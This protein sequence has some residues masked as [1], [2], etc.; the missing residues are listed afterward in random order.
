MVTVGPRRVAAVNVSIPP[1]ALRVGD[2]V[3][4]A[5]VP[6]DKHHGPIAQPVRWLSEDPAVA[7]VADDGTLTA[8]AAG[9]VLVWAEA[10]GVRGT[11][12]VEVTPA[13]VVSI[14]LGPIPESIGAGETFTVAATPVD[15]QGNTL[16]GRVCVWSSGNEAVGTVTEDG[17]VHT[18][19]SGSLPLVC[20]CEGKVVT[21]SVV[22]GWGAVQSVFISPPPP[23]IEAGVPFTLEAWVVSETGAVVDSSEVSWASSDPDLAMVAAGGRVSPRAPGDVVITASAGGVDASVS[24]GVAPSS[25]GWQPPESDEAIVEP[26][27]ALTTSAIFS[28]PAPTERAAPEF[29][30]NARPSGPNW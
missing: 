26:V 19:R 27:D 5:A 23:V 12:R 9:S 15:A 11:A 3:R 18:L 6:E 24:F 22:V 14:Q 20:T 29:T 10:E 17:V 30:S 4:L 2:R 25:T 16:P 7:S 1:G 28:S 13:Q 21:A 8:K